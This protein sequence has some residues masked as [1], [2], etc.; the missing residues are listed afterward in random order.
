MLYGLT[1]K[2]N[3]TSTR[4]EFRKIV[5]GIDAKEIIYIEDAPTFTLSLASGEQRTVT[6]VSKK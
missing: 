2:Q 6:F 1:L 3:I 4:D 5:L